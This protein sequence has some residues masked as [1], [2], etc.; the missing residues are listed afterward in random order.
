M[1]LSWR[2]TPGQ[3]ADVPEPPR[4]FAMP[5][6]KRDPEH[7]QPPNFRLPLRKEQLRSVWWM[8]EQERAANKTH[9]FVEEEIS[10]ALL[11]SLGWRAEGK[12]ERPVMVRGGVIADEVGYGKTIISLALAA[13]TKGDKAPSSAPETLIDLKAT[14][15]VVPGHLSKQ[16][17]SE[18]ERFTGDLFNLVVI[19]NHKDLQGKSIAELRKADII[20]VASEIFESEAYWQRFE[21][22]SA[23]PQEWLHEANGGRFFADRLDSALETLQ[24]QTAILQSQGA[25]AARVN[26]KV[27][28]RR[29]EAEAESKKDEMRAANFGKRLKGAAYRDKY[30]DQPVKK[31]AK[32]AKS[33]TG[34]WEEEEEQEFDESIPKPTFR[35]ADGLESLASSTVQKDCSLMRT[36]VLHMFRYVSCGLARPDS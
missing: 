5:S 2:L 8:L 24:E 31:K 28:H 3:V 11:P 22:L 34:R 21:Y 26:M 30:D 36:P 33:G 10:E 32:V 35:K 15:I 6:N 25:E 23:Q 1:R 27:L 12:A 14:L 16:W 13:E 29:A 9:T 18:I 19:Q 17:P 7:T 4:V 20:V